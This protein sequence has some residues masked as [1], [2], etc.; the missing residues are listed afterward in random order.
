[1]FIIEAV[2]TITIRDFAAAV[3]GAERRCRWRRR[4][5]ITAIPRRYSQMVRVA[6][7]SPKRRRWDPEEEHA[8]WQTDRKQKKI[9]GGKI[10]SSDEAMQSGAET[11]NSLESG[12]D[13]PGYELPAE[14]DCV[15]S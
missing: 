2:K 11:E 6:R 1:M 8:R 5:I 7:K 3:A 4:Y 12:D 9:S 14:S 13:L 15:M 10:S